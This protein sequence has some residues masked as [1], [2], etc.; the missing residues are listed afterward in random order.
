MYD[1]GA[2]NMVGKGA[3]TEV[4]PQSMVLGSWWE[5]KGKLS[6]L[7]KTTDEVVTFPSDVCWPVLSAG[8]V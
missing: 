6:F 4:Y 8:E 5:G 3:T 2:S 7:L 1:A